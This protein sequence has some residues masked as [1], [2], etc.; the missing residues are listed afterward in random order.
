MD[1]GLCLFWRQ[2]SPLEAWINKK[3]DFS[4]RKEGQ[5]DRDALEQAVW[6]QDIVDTDTLEQQLK[7]LS[8][9]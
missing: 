7:Y 3:Q 4:G 5:G 6:R 9:G 2:P 8:T 1:S